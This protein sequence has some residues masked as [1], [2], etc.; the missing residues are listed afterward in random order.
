MQRNQNSMMRSSFLADKIRIKLN[1]HCSPWV[2]DLSHI[3]AKSTNT[4]FFKYIH[5]CLSKCQAKIVSYYYGCLG[6]EEVTSQV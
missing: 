4:D 2:E 6:P 1:E 3:I 5:E